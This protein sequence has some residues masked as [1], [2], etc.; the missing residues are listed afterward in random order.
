MRLA[1]ISIVLVLLLAAATRFHDLGA[2][3]LWNDEGSSYVQSTRSF[4]EIAENAAADI[5]PPGYYWLLKVWRGVAGESEWALRFPSA[6]ASVLSV[7]LV[8]RLA[9]TLYPFRRGYGALAGTVAALLVTLNT[10]QIYY[11]QEARMY[12]LLGLWSVAS[13]VALARL[14]YRPTTGNAVLLGVLNALGLW[15][16][17]AFPLVMLAQG[18]VALIALAA[19]RTRRTL[20]AYVGG[21]LFALALFAPLLPTALRQ[22]TTWPNTGAGVPAAEALRAVLDWLAFGMTYAESNTAW[23]SIVLLLV[24]SGYVM[25]ASV[26]PTG[27]KIGI[28]AGGRC[29]RCY[30]SSFR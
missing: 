15:T 3:S 13:M 20:T 1:N 6:L 7:A 17:Y 16:Q 23:L 2:Q 22:V 26:M 8:H 14:F 29:C 9:T 27:C 12:A 28:R 21:N 30:G 4:T 18:A 11:A 25:R 24:L 10:F 19:L 5:H